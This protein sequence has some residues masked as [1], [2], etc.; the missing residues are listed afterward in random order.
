MNRTKHTRVSRF[1][2]F[3]LLKSFRKMHTN[4]RFALT[5]LVLLTAIGEDK[6]L[7]RRFL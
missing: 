7:K 5:N 6:A 2:T 4:T 1:I 3:T